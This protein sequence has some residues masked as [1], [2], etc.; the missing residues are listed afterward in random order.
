MNLWDVCVDYYGYIVEFG[1]VCG[2]ISIF[3]AVQR[4]RGLVLE[5]DNGENLKLS[6]PR[7]Q[8]S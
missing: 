3:L 2:S 6:V 5:F 7:A 8:I 4:G 1:V